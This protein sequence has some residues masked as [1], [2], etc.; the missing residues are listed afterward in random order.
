MLANSVSPAARRQLD[1]VEQRSLRGMGS[2]RHIRVPVVTGLGPALGPPV[3]DFVR[4][5][6]YRRFAG[7]QVLEHRLLKLI[8]LAEQGPEAA[9]EGDVLRRRQI[10]ISDHQQP[11]MFKP[12]LAQPG[13]SVVLQG[14]GEVEPAHFGPQHRTQLLDLH[15]QRPRACDGNNSR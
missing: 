11:V 15:A 7:Q 9:T 5:A 13:E 1:R 10:L 3:L 6:E 12:R 8:G 14:L 2:E 4:D